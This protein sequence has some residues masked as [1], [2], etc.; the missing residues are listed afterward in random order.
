LNLCR[1]IEDIKVQLQGD[2]TLVVSGRR[3]EETTSSSD[4]QLTTEQ[5]L[6]ETATAVTIERPFGSFIRSF[7]L[8]SNIEPEGITAIIQDGVLTVTLPKIEAQS[9]EIPVTVAH[10]IT[11]AIRRAQSID[12][13]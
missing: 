13:V 2:N 3:K 11:M 12:S 8:P 7:K 6:E 9:K 10:D 1:S 4:Q 5:G